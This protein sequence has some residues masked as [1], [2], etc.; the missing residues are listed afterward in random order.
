MGGSLKETAEGPGISIIIPVKEEEETVPELSEEIEQTLS[1]CPWS[2]ECIWIDDGST[3]RTLDALVTIHARN[4]R[5]RWICL[6]RNFG[7]SAALSA[8][9]RAARGRIFVTLDGDGQNDPADIPLLLHRYLKGD[10]DLVNGLRRKRQDG[11]V[12]RASSR[13]ANGFRNWMTGESVRDVGCALRVFNRCCVEHVPVFKGMHRFFPTLLRITGYGKMV[14]VAV[15]HRPRARGKTKYGIRNRLWVG[16][17]DTF[18]VCWMKHRM[19]LPRV[20]ASS[21]EGE[22]F[23]R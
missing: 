9:F 19:I 11:F 8:G 16:L 3:D 2:W 10:V 5:H 18:A 15:R 12:R 6:E 1:G 20:K 23:K 7:Q 14:E 22:A 17:A 4:P 21:G 13:I